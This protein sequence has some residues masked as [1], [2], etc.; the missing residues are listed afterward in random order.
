[1][2]I[3]TDSVFLT[4]KDV[5]SIGNEAF[6]DL[7]KRHEEKARQNLKQNGKAQA[8]YF[9]FGQDRVNGGCTWELTFKPLKARK[10]KR[11]SSKLGRLG[12]SVH[13]VYNHERYFRFLDA[14]KLDEQKPRRRRATHDGYGVGG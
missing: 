13:G 9:I 11:V 14:K 6:W 5:E 3:F 10:Y 8:I 12:F 4:S 1:M 2:Q 7:F